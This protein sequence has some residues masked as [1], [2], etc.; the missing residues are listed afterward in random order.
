V[1]KIASVSFTTVDVDLPA[2]VVVGG[3]AVTL[4]LG[5]VPQG[6]P[7]IV[8]SAGTPVELAITQAGTYHVEVA[9]IA[10]SGEAIAGPAA[11][12]PFVI[13]PDQVAVPFA[14]TVMISAEV[15]ATVTVAV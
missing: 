2:G 14:V 10:D 4:F 8:A 3:Y 12:D 15:P 6:S 5:D 13:A 9:R 11:S 1:N 7:V